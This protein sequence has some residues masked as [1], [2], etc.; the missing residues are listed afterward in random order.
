MFIR[1]MACAL[2]LVA[3]PASA[4]VKPKI[5]IIFDTSGS[6]MRDSGGNFHNGDGSPLCGNVGTQTR[7]YQ[8]KSALF[9]SLQG[10]GNSELDFALATYPMMVDPMRTPECFT[11]CVFNGIP[12]SG[13]YYVVPAQNWEYPPDVFGMHHACKISTHLQCTAASQC[14]AGGA[15]NSNICSVPSTAMKNGN[16][17]DASNPCFWYGDYKKEVLKVPFGQPIEDILWYFDN[18]EDAGKVAVLTNPEVRAATGTAAWW[19]PLGK[20]LFYAHG[21]F[22]KEVALP[23][24]DYRKACEKLVIAFFTDGGETCNV[25]PTDPFYPLTWAGN[26]ANNAKLKVTT[27]T[28]GIDIDPTTAAFLQSIA[29]S[30]K[31][32]YYNV[33][34]NTAA[35]KAAFL[36]IIAKA[37]PP[38]ET[39][40]GK[41][42][43][44]DNLVDE[45]FPQK[46]Q[47]CNNGKLGVCFKTGT[48][49]CKADGSGLVCNAPNA[50]GSAEICDGLDNDCDGSVDE[51]IPGGCTKLCQPEVCNGLDD[52]CDGTPDNNIPTVP[53]GKD[54]GECKAGT[55]KCIGGKVVCE[56]GTVPTTE[57]CDNKDNDC[58]G[59]ID[60]IGEP[61]YSG[62]SGCDVKTGQCKGICQLGTRVCSAG[63]WGACQGEVVPS[64]EICNGVDD[65]CD[66]SV[67]ENAECP[68]GGQC[69][70]G[71][72]TQK[73]GGSEFGCPKGQLCKD[74]WCVADTCDFVSCEA[75]GWVCKAG[76]CVD[77]CKEKSCG[78]TEVCQ[79][80]VCVDQSCYSKGCPAGETCV[81]GVC[82][83]NPCAGAKCKDDEF[84]Q[85]G[86]CVKLCDAVFCP[87]G[88]SCKVLVEGGKTLTRCVKDPC[89]N[90]ICATGKGEVCVDGKCVADPCAGVSCPN[91]GEV[92]V[93]GKCVPDL[94]ELTTCPI[95][96]HCEKGV[97]L[98]ANIEN[99][100]ELLASGGGGCS[101]RLTD[102]GEQGTGLLVLLALALGLAARR[103]GARAHS[104]STRG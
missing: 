32:T 79:K 10:M 102:E 18:K 38:T 14:G 98:A 99:T 75:K 76:E 86:T 29:A 66:G 49:A 53:C 16:C 54:V 94:C 6:M 57:L 103:R 61:C 59:T 85:S 82:Q 50:N 21:Y 45:D 47:P 37:R 1:L 73:C 80:G 81:Q 63:V 36:D 46:G 70:N 35:L 71:Q 84:C 58:D 31:G 40:N 39:C 8:L 55:A 78:K 104:R 90:V 30:G 96:Y 100:T 12:C 51:D 48:Y 97:C 13:H 22:D 67:D 93:A 25:S 19:T 42:D 34:G 64:K 44:C 91:K 5:M 52:D 77:P 11:T 65:N 27:H 89:Q 9:E 41:D 72:C 26:L 4:Q 56:G 43:D 87:T 23:A 15:C 83:K 3:M 101:C 17:S 92:C 69:I 33:A 68:G 88:E 62:T 28:V 60:G 74:G 7:I 24:T 95:G 2:L 20:S